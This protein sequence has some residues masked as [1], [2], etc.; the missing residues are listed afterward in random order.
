MA[1]GIHLD[2]IQA[3]AVN[4]HYGALNIYQVVFAQTRGPFNPSSV[5]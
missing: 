4:G 1:A 3:A 5:P 2:T